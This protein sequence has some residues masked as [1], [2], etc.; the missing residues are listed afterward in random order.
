MKDRIAASRCNTRIDARGQQTE[1]KTNLPSKRKRSGATI[2][3]RKKCQAKYERII[4]KYEA[5]ARRV[6]HRLHGAICDQGIN[7]SVRYRV[8][9]FDSYFAKL[10][11]LRRGGT[12][13]APITDL[14][15][16]RIICAFLA[17][18]EEVEQVIQAH[19][20]VIQIERKA[21]Q[22]SFR[23][24]GYDSTHLLIDLAD[25]LPRETVPYTKRV[26]EIQLR[27]ILQDAWAEIEHEL[28]YK[29]ESTLLSEPIKRKLASL[30]ATLTLS[31]LIFQELRD[32]QK[33][34]QRRDTCRKD[35]LQE[36]MLPSEILAPSE[37]MARPLEAGSSQQAPA[38][39]R[40]SDIDRLIF[41]AL[42]A[43]GNSE[44]VKAVALYSRVL[45]MKPHRNVRSTIYNHRGMTYFVLS[46]Y[47]QAIQ[48]YS[49]AIHYNPEN[50][51]A[52]NNRALAYRITQRYERALRDLD[53]SLEIN[54][55]QSEGYYIRALTYSDLQDYAKALEDCRKVLNIKPGF[56]AV[57]H[58]MAVIASRFMK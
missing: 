15:G 10:L 50:F 12:A 14:V 6:A 35:S 17:D 27:T 45:Q 37:A 43:H 25:K 48:D 38:V 42:A 23:Q 51:R 24:F 53:C 54:A 44:F 33:E 26:G 18:L 34:V 57:R 28:I 19:F 46:Q 22:H 21:A 41:E 32:Y 49:R 8:K 36:K 40:G 55:A 52:Y 20:R 2:P 9:S 47:R 11:Q 1:R 39:Q 31:D 58:L 16:F 13:P 30:N 7:A 4:P 3:S 56:T 29:A 5:A